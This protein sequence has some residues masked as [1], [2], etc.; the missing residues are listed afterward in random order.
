M[1]KLTEYKQLLSKNYDK[2][3]EFLLKKY[4]TAE[5]DYFNEKSYERF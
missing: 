3:V 2:A 5:D 1:T 4:G